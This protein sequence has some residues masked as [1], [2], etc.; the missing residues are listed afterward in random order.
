MAKPKQIAAKQFLR[1]SGASEI[2]LRAL[3]NRIGVDAFETL[4]SKGCDSEALAGCF[5]WLRALRH[6][7]P[8]VVTDNDGSDVLISFRM[9]DNEKTALGGF[10]LRK[11]KRI[12]KQAADLKK[13]IRELAKTYLVQ[14]FISTGD[15]ADSDLLASGLLLDSRFQ[16]LLRLPILAHRSGRKKSSDFK[17][18][19]LSMVDLVKRSSGRPHY[20]QIAYVLADLQLPYC[21][22]A[23]L[24]QL[25]SRDD[26]KPSSKSPHSHQRRSSK[27][28][29]KVA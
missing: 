20:S 26:R 13:Q 25:C 6:D 24:K 21:D 2:E 7:K 5:L 17:R 15:I 23:S 1:S 14:H 27:T 8:E 12:R 19:I 4:C 18:A 16:G 11:L 29:Q 10:D 22:E 3:L 9:L 28:R